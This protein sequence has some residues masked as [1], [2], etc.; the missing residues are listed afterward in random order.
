M[1]TSPGFAPEAA[2]PSADAILAQ[3]A[4]I[5]EMGFE[6]A[7]VLHVAAAAA[8]AM[9][10][11][12]WR[13]SRRT[14]GLIAAAPMSTVSACAFTVGNPF[15]G[16][17]FAALALVLG[18]LAL[19]AT[20]EAAQPGPAWASLVGGALV[21]L[22]LFYPHFLETRSALAYVVG[23]PTGLIPCPTLALA[24]GLYLLA[25]A[26]AGKTAALVLAAAAMFYGFVGVAQLGIWLDVGLLLAALALPAAAFW[27]A[28]PAMRLRHG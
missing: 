16:A 19:R 7:F 3:A 17:I 28:A 5:A 27:P 13:P 18:G 12:G 8:L 1:Q 22:A 21:V 24:S 14:V 6:L 15:N 25:D 4:Q 9:L 26:P 20:P 2:M 11:A 23:A 10:L